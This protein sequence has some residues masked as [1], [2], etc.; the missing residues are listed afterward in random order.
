MWPVEACRD[1]PVQ[2]GA[3]PLQAV[4]R[5]LLI[6]PRS[7]IIL[8]A[9]RL[10]AAAYARIISSRGRFRGREVAEIGGARDWVADERRMRLV[11]AVFPYVD[12]CVMRS[13]LAADDSRGSIRAK[14]WAIG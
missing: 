3:R 11:A 12:R 7:D 1:R 4:D 9:A 14:G 10:V 8:W 6:C 2:L 5:F 13:L